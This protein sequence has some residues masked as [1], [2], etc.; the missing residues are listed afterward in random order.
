VAQIRGGHFRIAFLAASAF[1]KNPNAPYF[2]DELRKSGYVDGQNLALEVRSAEGQPERLPV[3]AAELVTLHPDVIVALSTPSVIALKS[4]GTSIPVVFIG[5]SD[6]V[7]VGI[8]ES[9]PHPGGTFTG[10]TNNTGELAPKRLQLLTELIPHLTRV[11]MLQNPNNVASIGLVNETEKASSVLGIEILPIDYLRGEEL[12]EA[13][14]RAMRAGA[15]ALV[16]SGDTIAVQSY[17]KTIIETAREKR[18]P[19]MYTTR[20]EVAEGGLISYSADYQEQWRH[21]ATYVDKILHGSKP[22]DLPVE[23]PTRFILAINLKTAE[24]LGI[25]PPRNMLALAD[26]VID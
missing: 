24:E 14:E 2:T 25:Q 15:Q 12:P 1:S 3:L 13:I 5:V 20:T 21:A 17:R 8:V 11:G 19:V 10:I 6:P 16:S 7:G 22:A 23:Q 18:L 26:E 9:I 4:L